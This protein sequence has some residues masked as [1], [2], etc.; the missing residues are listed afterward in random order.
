MSL[1]LKRAKL[2]AAALKTW[3]FPWGWLS[4]TDCPGFA[5]APREQPIGQL[6]FFDLCSASRFSSSLSSWPSCSC[7]SS[8]VNEAEA[9]CRN[10]QNGACAPS[11]EGN[12]E[13]EQSFYNGS[14]HWHQRASAMS[15]HEALSQALLNR[16]SI[17]SFGKSGP[18]GRTTH[19]SL[20]AEDK[21]PKSVRFGQASWALQGAALVHSTVTSEPA[22]EA[23]TAPMKKKVRVVAE[24][25]SRKFNCSF[26]GDPLLQN[27]ALIFCLSQI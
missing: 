7:P 20:S 11:E 21:W 23:V 24:C 3:R 25:H 2:A 9:H 14:P 12:L 10:T 26:E 15:S 18:W 4:E 5:A 16:F 22:A 8:P 6:A 19:P 13:A 17:I 27:S 1:S